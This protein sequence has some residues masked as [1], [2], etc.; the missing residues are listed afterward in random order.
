MTEESDG[1]IL[2]DKVCNFDELKMPLLREII[3]K[4]GKLSGDVSIILISKVF[5]C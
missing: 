4:I 2:I 1:Q 5:T 3:Q